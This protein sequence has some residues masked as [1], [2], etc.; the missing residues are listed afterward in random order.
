MKWDRRPPA[1][2]QHTHTYTHV[3][4]QT[5]AAWKQWPGTSPDYLLR[6]HGVTVA[7]QRRE[8]R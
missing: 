4:M 6:R 2:I 7:W 1:Q 5:G 3:Y 8:I